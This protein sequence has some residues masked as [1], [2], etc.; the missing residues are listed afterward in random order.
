MTS[1]PPIVVGAVAGAAAAGQ[2]SAALKLIFALLML[3]RVLNAL[4]LP[5]MT[6]YAA[7]RPADLPGLVAAMARSVIHLGVPLTILGALLAPWL[8][9]MAFGPGYGEA[10]PLFRIL[11]PYVG[12]TLISSTCAVLLL[13]AGRERRYTILMLRAAAV[14][15]ALVVG[16]TLL[17]GTEGAAWG[18]LAGEA[19]A[20]V[21]LAREAGGVAGFRLHRVLA[22]P[23][24]VTVPLLIVFLFPA[25]ASPAALAVVTLG[26]GLAT[27]GIMLGN[28]REDVRFFRG[29]LL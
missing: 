18:V 28:G 25:P 27:L 13:A 24:A 1:L 14:L 15:V 26:I 6:R 16:L 10:V 21:L 29:R 7:T 20:L 3:D 17:L 12:M 19:A 2:F 4:L 22:R 5:V 11:L 8:V 9:P 23:L